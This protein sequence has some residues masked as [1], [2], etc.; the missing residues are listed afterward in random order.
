M[1]LEEEGTE[2]QVKTSADI[3]VERRISGAWLDFSQDPKASSSSPRVGYKKAI[4]RAEPRYTL[5]P[6]LVRI[7]D[8]K[9][10]P[11][12]ASGQTVAY[13]RHLLT[14]CPSA[15]VRRLEYERVRL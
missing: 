8:G 1:R 4:S 3:P 10:L 11:D 6:G 15:L 2:T 13:M 12:V 5:N 9:L 14:F 7:F